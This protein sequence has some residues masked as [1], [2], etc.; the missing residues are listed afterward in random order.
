[1]LLLIA[2]Q[3]SLL[4]AINLGSLNLPHLTDNGAKNL[5]EFGAPAMQALERVMLALER[6]ANGKTGF[7]I[8]LAV[9]GMVIYKGMV[10]IHQEFFP[11]SQATTKV[12]HSGTVVQVHRNE[13]GQ[14]Q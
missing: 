5:S 4:P 1:M 13:P 8:A 11:N 3:M 14:Q 12:D 7:T 2:L 9:A 10:A 6:V